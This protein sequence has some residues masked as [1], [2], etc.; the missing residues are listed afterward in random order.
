MSIYSK[1]YSLLTAANNKT[2]ESDTTLTDAVQTL[3]DGYGQGGG[4]TWTEFTATSTAGNT[5]AARDLLFPSYSTSTSVVVAALLKNKS[6]ADFPNNQFVGLTVFK[7]PIFGSALSNA[8]AQASR[9]RNGAYGTASIATNYDGI[10][11]VGDTFDLLEV[12]YE[13][14]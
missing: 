11:E 6:V 4:A 2:G 9:Y 8:I 12:E 13:V 14:L 10:I 3:I 5:Q 7:N 1:L